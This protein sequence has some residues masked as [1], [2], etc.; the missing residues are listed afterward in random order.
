[1]IKETEKSGQSPKSSTA[2]EREKLNGKSG[3]REV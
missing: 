2:I 3:F 1:M